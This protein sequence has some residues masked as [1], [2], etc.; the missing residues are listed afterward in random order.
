MFNFFKRFKKEDPEITYLRNKIR[1]LSMES[2]FRNNKISATLVKEKY[3]FPI[4]CHNIKTSTGYLESLYNSFECYQN[5]FVENA[6]VKRISH[7]ITRSVKYIT[8]SASVNR[9][10][11]TEKMDNFEFEKWI[12][13]YK[14][15]LVEMLVYYKLCS[16]ILLIRKDIIDD[17]IDK[18]DSMIFFKFIERMMTGIKREMDIHSNANDISFDTS[19]NSTELDYIESTK[20]CTKMMDDVILFAFNTNPVLYTMKDSIEYYS[21]GIYTKCVRLE[22]KEKETDKLL[23]Y[24]SGWINEPHK[25][26]NMYMISSIVLMTKYM[27]FESKE[28]EA[29]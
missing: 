29:E 1:T 10:E 4:P 16:M 20:K 28:S 18:K 19:F 9:K 13:D 24:A 7:L 3:G 23:T 14:E 12:G 5:M 22:Y 25:D 15:S 21:M 6:D 27:E 26:E 2:N 11:N 17:S 8:R